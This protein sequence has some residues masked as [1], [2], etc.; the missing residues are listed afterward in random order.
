MINK[1]NEDRH[2]HIITIE[3]PIEFL[4]PNKNC[5]VNQREVHADTHSFANSCALPCGR[6]LTWCLSGRCVTWKR[7]K[8]RCASL[9]PGT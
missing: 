9:K 4:H 2:E 7:L 6:T 3:D 5:L 1:I 8:R